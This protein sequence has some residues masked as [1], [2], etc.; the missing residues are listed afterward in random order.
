TNGAEMYDNNYQ[1]DFPE[2]YHNEY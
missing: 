1:T 2:K